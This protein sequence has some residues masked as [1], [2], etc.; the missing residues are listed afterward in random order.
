METAE[1]PTLKELDRQQPQARRITTA[2]GHSQ[3]VCP[4]D[5]PQYDQEWINPREQYLFAKGWER[6]PASGNLTT[7]RDPKGSMAKGEYREVATLPVKGDDTTKTM[8]IQQYHVPPACYSFTLEE[9]LDIQR[10]RDAAGESG[11]TPLDRLA[12][13]ETR[14][15]ELARQL[16]Q[17]KARVALLLTTPQMTHEGLKLGLRQLLNG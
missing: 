14:C 16:E 11:E 8:V 1:A 9:A 7:Y 3:I 13:C 4:P 5:V 12:T 2:S 10:R 17:F 6:D 15:N